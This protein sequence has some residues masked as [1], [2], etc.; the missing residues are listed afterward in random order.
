MA[1]SRADDKTGLGAIERRLADDDPAL[2]EAFQQW[3]VPEDAPDT[4]DGETT[5]PPWVLAVFVTAAVA[6]VVSPGFGVLVAAV[7]LFWVLVDADQR[8][9]RLGSVRCAHTWRSSRQPGTDEGAGP[10]C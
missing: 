2:A 6:W 7:A 10:K 1:M 3:K 4:Q 8:R 9:G 5:A